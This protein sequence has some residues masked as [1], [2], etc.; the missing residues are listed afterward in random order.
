MPSIIFPLNYIVDRLLGC[1]LHQACKAYRLQVNGD[2]WMVLLH[3]LESIL[4][5]LKVR[6]QRLKLAVMRTARAFICLPSLLNAESRSDF[7]K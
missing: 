1:Y 6:Q 3:F 4:H 2:Y 7:R 5:G